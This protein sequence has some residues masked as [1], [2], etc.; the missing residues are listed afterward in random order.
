M[1][2]FC[3][4]RDSGTRV[5]NWS[6]LLSFLRQG[7]L[8]P[9]VWVSIDD[10]ARARLPRVFRSSSHTSERVVFDR[11]RFERV[12]EPGTVSSRVIIAPECCIEAIG[13]LCGNAAVLPT[14]RPPRTNPFSR[15]ITRSC[16]HR[17]DATRSPPHIWVAQL[18]RNKADGTDQRQKGIKIEVPKLVPP[19]RT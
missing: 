15:P 9:E 10:S 12:T 4:I 14:Q 7:Q 18:A 8:P 2:G 3:Q 6:R 16:R 11:W 19:K 13:I 17:S 5:A 1:F